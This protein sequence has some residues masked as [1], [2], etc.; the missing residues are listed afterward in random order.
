[1]NATAEQDISVTNPAPPYV[2]EVLCSAEKQ[3]AALLHNKAEIVRRIGTIKKMLAGMASLYGDSI[4]NEE[5]LSALDRGKNNSRKGFTPA[6]R[7]VLMES[8]TPMRTGQACVELRKRFPDLV[9]HHKDLRASVITVFH[10]LVKYGQARFF[11]DD[12]GLKVWEWVTDRDGGDAGYTL[13]A[14]SLS[15]ASGRG[16]V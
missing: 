16:T 12:K 9:G 5:V 1:M 11:V 3:L 8:G 13:P 10:R 2:L 7:Q 15:S 14:S 6:C 4:L